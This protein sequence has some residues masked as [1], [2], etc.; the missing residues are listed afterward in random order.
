M[1]KLIM[2]CGMISL[3]LM[4]A[5]GQLEDVDNT[6]N[7]KSLGQEQKENLNQDKNNNHN[8]ASN[9][10]EKAGQTVN[11]NNQFFELKLYSEQ[12]EYKT[13]D[14]IKLWATLRYTGKEEQITIWH[15]EPYLVFQ[16][17]DGKKF[18]VN[19]V[20]LT[21]LKSTT[22]D[23]DTLYRTNYVKSG[24]Y[25]ANADDASFW[26][27]FYDEKELYLPKGEYTVRVYSAFSMTSDVID[28][29]VTLQDTLK[30]KVT[31]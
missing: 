8:E 18:D 27:M 20:M 29:E 6:D 3:L 24:G 12:T 26:K 9:G 28:S 5:C 16:I 31:N 30:I 1:K 21:I 4:T 11:K 25:D 13:T 17:T 15:G 10:T 23:R 2:I 14:I 19:G 7:T 22:L